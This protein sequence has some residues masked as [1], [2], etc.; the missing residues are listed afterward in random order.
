[1]S[2]ALDLL[3]VQVLALTEFAKTFDFRFE[4]RPINSGESRH[5]NSS[6][7]EM[8]SAPVQEFYIPASAL[9]SSLKLKWRFRRQKVCKL[10]L[11]F[12]LKGQSLVRTLG[13]L[14]LESEV[15]ALIP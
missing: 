3:S 15:A 8:P 7:S 10:T 14:R 12:L 9:L 1:M 13:G 6:G 5:I 4:Q 2:A 11:F